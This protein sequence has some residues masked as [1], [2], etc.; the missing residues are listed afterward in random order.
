MTPATC[1]SCM[2]HFAYN[3]Y[4]QPPMMLISMSGNTVA[5]LPSKYCWLQLHLVE[6]GFLGL[7]KPLLEVYPTISIANEVCHDHG[8]LS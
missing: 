8:Q 2:H 7:L 1:S 3:L 4:G 5:D 6:C